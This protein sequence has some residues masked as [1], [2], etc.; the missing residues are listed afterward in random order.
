MPAF[1]RPLSHG[2]DPSGPKKLNEV[3]F[4][5]KER[6]WREITFIAFRLLLPLRPIRSMFAQAFR[7]VVPRR[8]RLNGRRPAACAPEFRVDVLA[9]SSCLLQMEFD[10]CRK[11]H[12]RSFEI[13]WFRRPGNEFRMPCEGPGL[14]LIQRPIWSGKFELHPHTSRRTVEVARAAGGVFPRS[15]GRPSSRD[16][17]CSIG[18]P[19]SRPGRKR[20]LR[21]A[22]RT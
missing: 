16:S 17:H 19:E 5:W 10:A 6:E 12:R 11:R 20:R 22:S 1:T 2:F 3:V 14:R 21:S 8:R 7:L 13:R 9:L 4:D 15:A 18:R